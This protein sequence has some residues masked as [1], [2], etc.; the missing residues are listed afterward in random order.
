MHHDEGS[1]PQPGLCHRTRL[2][3][4]SALKL[5]EEGLARAGGPGARRLRSECVPMARAGPRAPGPAQV[6]RKGK[7][8]RFP[9]SR[10]LSV[11]VKK[12]HRT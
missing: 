1:W 7:T 4:C 10:S 3:R 5:G 11:Y 9:F 6:G 8:Q 2:A 12:P